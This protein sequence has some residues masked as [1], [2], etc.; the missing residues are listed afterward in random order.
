MSGNTQDWNGQPGVP[1]G[2]LESEQ[3]VRDGLSRAYS[4]VAGDQQSAHDFFVASGPA[5]IGG[6]PQ[7]RRPGAQGDPDPA[8]DAS[9]G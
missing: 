3:A 1:G 2:R 6:H 9:D 8:L 7:V 4:A 5:E